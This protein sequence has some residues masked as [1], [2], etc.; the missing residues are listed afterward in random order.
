[1]VPAALE[2]DLDIASFLHLRR[3]ALRRQEFVFQV[4]RLNYRLVMNL[5]LN[6]D[7]PPEDT[8]PPCGQ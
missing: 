7:A 6:E 3:G 8:P 4:P 5:S 2:V 1:V